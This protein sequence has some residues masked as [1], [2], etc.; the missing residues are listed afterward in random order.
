M[1]ELKPNSAGIYES[2]GQKFRLGFHNAVWA[3]S[4]LGGIYD[5]TSVRRIAHRENVLSYGHDLYHYTSLVGLQGIIDESGFWA[6][7]NRFMNDA[8]EMSHGAELAVRVLQHCKRRCGSRHFGYI[9][10]EVLENFLSPPQIGNLVTCFS[11]AR[12]SLEQW[13]GY[14]PT[15]AVCIRLA[16][17]RPGTRPL[18]YGPHQLPYQA[19]YDTYP[20]IVLLMSI[21]RRF[22]R[23]YVLDRHIMSGNWPTNHDR[24]Y[25]EHLILLISHRTVAFK[26][27]SFKQEAEVRL[28]IPYSKVDQYEGGLKFRVGPLGLVPYVCT[29]N[30]KGVSGPLAISEVI[31]GPSSRQELISKSVRAFLDHKGYNATGVSLS[32]VP[33]RSQ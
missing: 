5:D 4:G 12:D 27:S 14:G 1:S 30:T 3:G 28:V 25:I 17:N 24:Q 22:E 29:G 2:G 33:F 8:T 9:L 19:F 32:V 15:G 18:F 11:Q 10:E 21:I 6:S 26:N 23:E 31:I 16:G 7:D 20:K 13:R